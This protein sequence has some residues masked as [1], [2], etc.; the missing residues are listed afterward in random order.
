MRGFLQKRREEVLKAMEIDMTFERRE[1]LI[2]EEERKIGEKI[3]EKI[4]SVN[5]KLV[6]IDELVSKG[7]ITPEDA[8][9]V[10]EEVNKETQTIKEGADK[11]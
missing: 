4:G 3:G 9:E 11:L 1:E 6:L 2:R 10:R 7:M 5:G 8:A